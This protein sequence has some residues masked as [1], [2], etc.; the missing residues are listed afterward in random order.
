MGGALGFC[1]AGIA[2]AEGIREGNAG[3][4]DADVV[5]GPA[6]DGDGADAFRGEVRAL[7]EAFFD[8]VDD[9]VE[10][11]AEAA[12]DLAWIIGEAMDELDQGP[13]I[14]PAKERYPATFCAE[15]YC[16]GGPVVVRTKRACG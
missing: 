14:I 1:V 3:G 2:V 8:A 11:P 16:D 12:V 7:A 10:V 5:D 15:V 6:I 9:A 4:V 13:G